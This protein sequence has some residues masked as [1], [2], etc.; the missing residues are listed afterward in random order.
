MYICQRGALA[1]T[2][3]VVWPKKYRQKANI[4]Y[5]RRRACIKNICGASGLYHLQATPP[6]GLRCS[7]QQS[8]AMANARSIDTYARR[9][10]QRR[11]AFGISVHGTM[12]L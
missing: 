5:M 7:L 10:L 11:H 2:A 9:V 8:N 4:M 3:L 1:L 12:S 6:P